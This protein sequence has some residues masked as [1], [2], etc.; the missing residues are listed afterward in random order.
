VHTKQILRIFS[1]P[2]DLVLAIVE[3][4]LFY[5]FSQLPYDLSISIA[6]EI[7]N[8]NKNYPIFPRI[9]SYS[10]DSL[11]LPISIKIA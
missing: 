8:M 2:K 4:T 11:A 3:F 10:F 1:H 9:K 6:H 7:Y 5:A